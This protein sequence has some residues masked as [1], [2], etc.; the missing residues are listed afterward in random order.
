MT[1]AADPAHPSS[2]ISPKDDH[3]RFVLRYVRAGA[4]RTFALYRLEDCLRKALEGAADAEAFFA[5]GDYE[6]RPSIVM[7]ARDGWVWADGE[8]K[9]DGRAVRVALSREGQLQMSARRSFDPGNPPRVVTQRFL[10]LAGSVFV[11]IARALHATLWSAA[12]TG[13]ADL[14]GLISSELLDVGNA[15]MLEHFPGNSFTQHV[16]SAEQMIAGDFN[17]VLGRA[18][19]P[20][21]DCIC[22]LG[23]QFRGPRGGLALDRKAL[24]EGLRTKPTE[25]A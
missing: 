13:S 6:R 10:S 14:T 25:P 3:Y 16:S 22:E 21:A 12:S 7:N 18:E 1:I 2:P 4:E 8:G 15:C 11:Q 20:V 17:C 24:I 19:E 5:R 23:I 9:G